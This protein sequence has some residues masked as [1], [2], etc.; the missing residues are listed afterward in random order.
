MCRDTH[1][2][3][4]KRTVNRLGGDIGLPLST[5]QRLAFLRKAVGSQWRS[6]I[7]GAFKAL[8]CLLAYR[9][10]SSEGP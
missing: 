4:H 8:I 9:S 6:L 3:W 7:M 1:I 5:H 2:F 10:I